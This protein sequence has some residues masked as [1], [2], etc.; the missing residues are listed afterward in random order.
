MMMTM[1]VIY[2][3]FCFSFSFYSF[4]FTAR[5]SAESM[6]DCHTSHNSTSLGV[7]HSLKTFFLSEY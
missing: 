6:I 2:L 7:G 4:L 1:T 3:T 5:C